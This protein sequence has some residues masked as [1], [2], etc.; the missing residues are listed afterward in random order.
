MSRHLDVQYGAAELR[1]NDPLVDEA[2]VLGWEIR[3]EGF[4]CSLRLERDDGESFPLSGSQ[5]SLLCV[6]FDARWRIVA[7]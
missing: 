5:Y 3:P 4:N 2:R 1:Q 6:V 7:D